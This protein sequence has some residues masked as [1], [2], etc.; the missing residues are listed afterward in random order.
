MFNVLRNHCL[1]GVYGICSDAWYIIHSKFVCCLLLW[2]RYLY[3]QRVAILDQCVR[4]MIISNRGVFSIRNTFNVNIILINFLNLFNF[5]KEDMT[6]LM[7]RRITMLMIN[8][9]IYW[10]WCKC[11]NWHKMLMKFL[12]VWGISQCESQDKN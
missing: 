7:F 3:W 10:N 2:R 11:F 5:L 4:L 1:E 12:Q 9:N 6:A 8:V